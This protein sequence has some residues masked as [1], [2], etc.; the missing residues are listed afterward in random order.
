MTPDSGILRRIILNEEH[1]ASLIKSVQEHGNQ[2]GGNLAHLKNFLDRLQKEQQTF[3]ADQTAAIDQAQTT[4]KRAAIFSAIAA[5]AAALGTLIQAGVAVKIYNRPSEIGPSA[6]QISSPQ[7]IARPN[8]KNPD[9]K[10]QA[11]II[12]G[13]TSPARF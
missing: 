9:A 3:L 10:F 7:I 11:S 1:S 2:L 12:P 8:L 4:A 13:S 6:Q 5:I